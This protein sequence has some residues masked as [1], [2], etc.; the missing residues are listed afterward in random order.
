MF[1]LYM[2]ENPYDLLTRV[3]HTFASLSKARA[4]AR[5][6]RAAQVEIRNEA[7]PRSRSLCAIYIEGQELA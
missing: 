6:L 7:L 1:R 5:A 4:K 2:Q 3:G